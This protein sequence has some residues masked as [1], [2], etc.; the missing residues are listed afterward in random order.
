MRAAIV[1]FAVSLARERERGTMRRLAAAPISAMHILAG[2]ALC[3]FFVCIIVQ[4]LILG[5]MR[6]L[7][8]RVT[9]GWQMTAAVL[10]CAFA[11]SGLMALL[12]G[13]CKSVEGASGLG[14]GVAIVL[15]LIGGG[16]VPIVFMPAFMQ[17][18]SY[19][20]PFRWASIA[21]EGAAWRNTNWADIFVPAAVLLA[22]GAIGFIMG[23]LTLRSLRDA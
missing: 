5:T 19:G 10:L 18:I 8:V 15:A 9:D 12:A 17:K 22:I 23:A 7:G 20:S 4:L 21:I 14:R 2:K 6:F 3:C 16:S 13:V 1:A 11:F